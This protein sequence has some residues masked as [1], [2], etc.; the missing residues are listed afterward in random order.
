MIEDAEER[1]VEAQR[2]ALMEEEA[3]YTRL[4]RVF[5]SSDGVEILEWLLELSGL[6]SRNISDERAFGKFELG[7]FVYNQISMADVG[8]AHKLLDRRVR[9]AQAVRNA[10]RQRIEKS[11]KG[12][13]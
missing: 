11:T 6:F 4:S 12:V 1:R 10:E 2:T 3:H 7:R 9:Q 8:I 13:E 5:G